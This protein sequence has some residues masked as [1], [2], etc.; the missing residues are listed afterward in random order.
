MNDFLTGEIEKYEQEKSRKVLHYLQGFVDDDWNCGDLLSLDYNYAT[1]LVHDYQRQQVGGIPLGSFLLATRISPKP[2]EVEDIEGEDASLILLRVVGKA[3]LPNEMEA[4][5]SR[6]QAGQRALDSTDTWDAEGKTDQFTLNQLRMSGL[7]CRVIGTYSAEFDE[8]NNVYTTFGADISNFYSGQ[9]MKVYKPH[10]AA[11]SAVVNFQRSESADAHE[12]HGNRVSIARVRY[13]AAEMREQSGAEYV[14]VDL[15]PTDL[16]AR[17]TA[18][19]GMSRT[20]KSNTTKIIASS[21]FR[22]REI[23]DRNSRVGQL[24]FDVNGEYAND[25]P[26]DSGCIRNIHKSTNSSTPED[27]VTYGTNPHPNDP[28]RKIL[29]INFFGEN[30]ADWTNSEQVSNALD[31]LFVGKQIL[32]D[33]LSGEEAKYISAFRDTSLEP[34]TEITRNISIRYQRAILAYRSILAGAGF[35]PPNNISLPKIN[36]LFNKD[37]ITALRQAAEEEESSDYDFAANTFEKASPSLEHLFYAFKALRQFIEKSAYYKEFNRQYMSKR[38]GSGEPWHDDRLTGILSLL[39]SNKGVRTLRKAHDQH[40]PNTAKDYAETIAD[41]LGKGKLVILDQSMGDPEYN[42]KAADRIAWA[43]FKR[44]QHY[45]INPERNENGS[46]LPPPE[47]LLFIEEAHNI[48]PSNSSTNLDKIWSRLAK[49]GSKYN[50]GLMFATQEP[51]SLQRN[52]LSNTD[53]WFVA[54]LNNSNEVREIS[55]YYDFEDFSDQIRKVPEPG[56]IRMRTL[57][58]PYIVPIQVN[59]FVADQKQEIDQTEGNG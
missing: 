7:S 49:E 39:E 3:P 12:L 29:K 42:Q 33:H 55:K 47:I 51:S 27:V 5:Q 43:V 59:K 50:I 48:L 40:D 52:I 22:L 4:E 57:S 25:N 45:F 6:F 2:S 10:D 31:P 13:A 16:L 18:L 24:I 30:P 19:F 32:D 56:F 58:N 15:D 41:E 8:N 28:N 36:S 44:Q 14:L 26:Q 35:T 23:E 21:V 34:P 1:I 20:G 11:L 46:I 38:G 54:H 17:R 53:N 37:L 9:G